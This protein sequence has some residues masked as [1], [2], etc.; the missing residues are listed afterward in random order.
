MKVAGWRGFRHKQRGQVCSWPLSH[1]W[2][3]GWHDWHGRNN[4]ARSRIEE[5][6]G[7]DTL[8][9]NQESRADLPRWIFAL[10]NPNS[11][12]LGPTPTGPFNRGLPTF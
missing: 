4:I 10:L 6:F 9:D 1:I 7:L 5:K 3:K 12:Q 2:P 11:F 8:R